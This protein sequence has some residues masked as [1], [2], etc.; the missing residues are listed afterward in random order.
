MKVVYK[1][2]LKENIS[3]YIPDKD[4]VS[5]KEG[6]MKIE[7]QVDKNNKLSFIHLIFHNVPFEDIHY[8]NYKCPRI[9][10]LE[11]RVYNTVSYIANQIRIETGVDI[12]DL[13]FIERMFIPDDILPETIEEKQKGI[14]DWMPPLPIKFN[15]INDRFEPLNFTSQFKLSQALAFYA[16]S[17]RVASPFTRYEQLFKIVE[18]FFCDSK[19]N[20]NF[21]DDVAEAVSLH[22][23]KYDTRFDSDTIKRLRYTRN[24]IMHPHAEKGHLNPADISAVRTLEPDIVLLQNLVII[25][26]KNPPSFKGAEEEKSG[27]GQS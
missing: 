21:N 26:L 16:D 20:R 15:V 7:W 9:P 10:H 22:A 3:L 11:K 12:I 18:Y 4:K 24:R 19:E 2:F 1:I 27:Q 17:R 25:L 5:I 14:T 13:D 6:T 8:D 23:N